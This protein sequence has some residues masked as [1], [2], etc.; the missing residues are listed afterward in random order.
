MTSA[1]HATIDADDERQILDAID[2]FLD[3]DVRP[4]VMALEHADEYPTDMVEGMK[5]L[6]LKGLYT[7]IHDIAHGIAHTI[8]TA[9]GFV[10]WLAT[11]SMDGVFGLVVGLILIPIVAKVIE[12]VWHMVRPGK[13]EASG[14]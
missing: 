12:P 4:H 3:R 6:G 14:H 11:A 7:T 9:E 13:A 2:K 1:A 10:A 8:G 5:E